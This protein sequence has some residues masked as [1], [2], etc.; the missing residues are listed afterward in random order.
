MGFTKGE[1]ERKEEEWRGGGTRR[2]KGE[3]RSDKIRIVLPL[4]YL[5]PT[6]TL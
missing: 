6:T 1:R 4:S 5:T 3:E 2:G